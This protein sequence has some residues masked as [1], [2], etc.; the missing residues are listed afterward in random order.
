MNKQ[1]QKKLGAWCSVKKVRHRIPNY[2]PESSFW[3]ISVLSLDYALPMKLV[4][5]A[6][7]ISFVLWQLCE[8][9][10]LRTCDFNIRSDIWLFQVRKVE[11]SKSV[12]AMELS[13]LREILGL[14]NVQMRM[15]RWKFVFFFLQAFVAL[16][17]LALV[18]HGASC[19]FF[20]CFRLPSLRQVVI[21]FAIYCA[22]ASV[23]PFD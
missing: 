22:L 19:G 12:A 5:T 8:M 14:V 21:I 18:L 3:H 7:I 2:C 6:N 20:F 10:R 16:V 1:R 15:S 11:L 13:A 23:Q 9:C 17:V 4:S